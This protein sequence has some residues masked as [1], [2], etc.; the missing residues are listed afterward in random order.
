M[1]V[2]M[3]KEN[4]AE[5]ESS[6]RFSKPRVIWGQRTR[7]R[8]HVERHAVLIRALFYLSFYIFT[9]FLWSF[10]ISNFGY[11][12]AELFQSTRI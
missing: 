6:L 2:N 9:G 11:Q 7:R 1:P 10:D 3:P 8:Y 12:F 4:R 5:L